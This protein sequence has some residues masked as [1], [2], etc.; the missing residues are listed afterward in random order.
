MTVQHLSVSIVNF[1]SALCPAVQTSWLMTFSIYIQSPTPSFFASLALW[2]SHHPPA[3]QLGGILPDLPLFPPPFLSLPLPSLLHLCRQT[4]PPVR[5]EKHVALWTEATY[6]HWAPTEQ[7]AH[8]GY[9]WI[10]SWFTVHP[11]LISPWLNTL[12]PDD[13]THRTADLVYRFRPDIRQQKTHWKPLLWRFVSTGINT[14][15]D[16]L[17]WTNCV[18]MF[19]AERYVTVVY[20]Q[21]NPQQQL[22]I[23]SRTWHFVKFFLSLP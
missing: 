3:P 5:R 18:A 15:L 20:L 10:I 11:L 21:Q 8:S 1:F 4:Q 16:F 12:S 7:H 14:Y 2:D 19:E 22:F 23:L 6:Q 9:T 17:L 13:I